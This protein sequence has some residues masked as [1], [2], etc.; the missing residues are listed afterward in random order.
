MG[1]SRRAKLS[2]RVPASLEPVPLPFPLPALLP[3]RGA[4]ILPR[5]ILYGVI[6]RAAGGPPVG[7]LIAVSGIVVALVSAVQPGNGP[8]PAAEK[9]PRHQVLTGDDAKRA[10]ELG[11]K[12]AELR[13]T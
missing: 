10:D 1:V 6:G 2:R 9:A 4:S 12:V 8:V 5:C 13:A 11:R 7:H 3:K